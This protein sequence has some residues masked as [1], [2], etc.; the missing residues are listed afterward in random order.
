MFNGAIL[1]P[2]LCTFWQGKH[3]KQVTGTK[4]RH[5][6]FLPMTRSHLLAYCCTVLV[7]VMKDRCLQPASKL[8]MDSDTAMGHVIVLLQYI[9]PEESDLFHLLIHRIRLKDNFSYPSFC[10]YVI[11]VDF[12]EE[13]SHLVADVKCKLALDITP[14]VTNQRRMGTRGANRGEKEEIKS[15]LKKQVARSNDNLD[16]I[17]IDFLKKYKDTILTCLM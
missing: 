2:V 1:I 13:F 8:S 5:V 15:A 16:D 11:H 12:L 3:L 9:F 10:N 4:S 14:S 6:H 7:Y 17:I